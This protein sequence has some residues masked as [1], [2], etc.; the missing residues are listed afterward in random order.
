MQPRVESFLHSIVATKSNVT[1]I[2][3]SILESISFIPSDVEKLAKLDV[4]V[5][6]QSYAWTR[7]K[8]LTKSLDLRRC[9]SQALSG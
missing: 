8:G 5:R 3:P 6:T 7:E 4:V 2:M 9:C 1:M